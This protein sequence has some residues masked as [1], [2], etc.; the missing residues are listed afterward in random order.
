M[1]KPSF[2]FLKIIGPGIAV[3][4]TGVGAGDMIAASVAGAQYGVI[5]LWA[6]VF[7]AVMKYVLNEGIARWQ[8]STGTTVLEGWISNFHKAV[9]VY[10]II[11]LLIWSFI[12]AAAL[13]TSCGLAANAIFPFLSVKWWGVIHS[14]LGAGIVL[15]GRYK[16]FENMVK[17]FI[18]IMF[19]TLVYCAV[20]VLPDTGN[21]F[22][23]IFIPV[24]PE[25]SGKFLLGVIGG[26]GGSVTLL[27]YGYW[28][29]EKGWTGKEMRRNSRIDL[30]TAYVLTGIFGIAVVIIAAGVNPEIVSGGK[31]VIEIA[32]RLESILGASG[33]WVFLIGFW[34]AVFTSLLGVWQG[35]PYLFTD[36]VTTYKRIKD[37][38][39]KPSEKKEKQYYNWYLLYLAVPP[40]LLL[41]FDKPVWV[42]IIY[43]ITG[44]FFM[45]FLALTLLYM[46]NKNKWVGDFKN[47]VIINILLVISLLVFGYLCYDTVVDLF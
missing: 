21:V 8:L 10:F 40:L 31:I 20:M 16:L 25:G 3:A 1:K 17:F 14:L 46:N 34:G 23:S 28:I 7:G 36:F 47:G 43:S 6:V 15:I 38:D 4:A 29:R 45:P 33:K 2:N 42:V 27:S 18:G 13:I 5:I 39:Y 11:Y 24:V 9:S 19:F 44:A 37:K 32:N 41:L 35:V 26:V 30:V 12:V 22:A